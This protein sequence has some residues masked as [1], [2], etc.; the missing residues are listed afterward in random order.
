MLR[1]DCLEQDDVDVGE[2]QLS[3]YR[4]SKRA[5]HHLRLGEEEVEYTLKLGSDVGCCR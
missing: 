5:E 4:L 3:H 2:L 1:V